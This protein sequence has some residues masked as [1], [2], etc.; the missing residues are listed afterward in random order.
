MLVLLAEMP[1][2]PPPEHVPSTPPTSENV[3]GFIDRILAGPDPRGYMEPVQRQIIGDIGPAPMIGVIK[4]PY[5]TSQKIYLD[6]FRAM[7]S[8]TITHPFVL[9]TV[10]GHGSIPHNILGGSNF[11]DDKLGGIKAKWVTETERSYVPM[12]LVTGTKILATGVRS[13]CVQFLG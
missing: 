2:T 3:S 9:S 10:A 12:D 5:S 6:D 8:N 13:E 4:Y 7:A 1:R 11:D